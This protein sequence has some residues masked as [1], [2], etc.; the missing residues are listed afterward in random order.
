MQPIILEMSYTEKKTTEEWL[1]DG[2]HGLALP[3]THRVALCSQGQAPPI[4]QAVHPCT[5]ARNSSCYPV[6]F[7]LEHYS[8]S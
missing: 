3:L 8:Y 5:C 2:L 7:H 4:H 6:G 1:R